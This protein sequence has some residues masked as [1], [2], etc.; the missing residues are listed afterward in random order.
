M[1]QTGLRLWIKM[2]KVVGQKAFRR[3]MCGKERREIM[4]E[5]ISSGRVTGLAEAGFAEC[6]TVSGCGS[7]E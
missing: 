7:R 5:V 3:K 2:Q 4:K 6:Q 1:Q